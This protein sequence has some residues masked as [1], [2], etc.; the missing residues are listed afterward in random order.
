MLMLN[1]HHVLMKR[2]SFAVGLSMLLGLTYTANFY[3]REEESKIRL[4]PRLF[5]LY[6]L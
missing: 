3:L 4:S 6:K 2:S 5:G 1:F